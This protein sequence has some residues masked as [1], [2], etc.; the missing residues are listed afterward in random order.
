[1]GKSQSRRGPSLVQFS[2]VHTAFLRP[3]DP[4]SCE[5]L[6]CIKYLV[7]RECRPRVLFRASVGLCAAYETISHAV[8]LSNAHFAKSFL[9]RMCGRMER[10][11]LRKGARVT[12]MRGKYE[13]F[14]NQHPDVLRYGIGFEAGKHSGRL[15]GFLVRT[16]GTKATLLLQLT[17]TKPIVKKNMTDAE[18]IASLEGPQE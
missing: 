3:Q 1:M 18:L 6:D 5:G 13:P 14:N 17:T 4:R 7:P 15:D 12:S 11:L 2:P 8:S 10:W 16:G 9:H